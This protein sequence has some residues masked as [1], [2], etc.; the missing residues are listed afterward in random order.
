MF[1]PLR[2]ICGIVVATIIAAAGFRKKSLSRDGAL[3]ACLVGTSHLLLGVRPGILLLAFFYSSSWVTKYEAAQKSNLEAGHKEGG[4]RT[5]VQVLANGGFGTA[6][7]VSHL[8]F[9]GGGEYPIDFVRH[10]WESLLMSMLLGNGDTWASEL[11]I[12][13]KGPVYLVTTFRKVP[14]GTNGGISALG[15]LA[16]V[17]GGL[18]IGTLY[19]LAST[20]LLGGSFGSQW[21][22]ILL[23]ACAG[24]VGSLVDSVCGALFEYSGYNSEDNLVYQKEQRGLKHIAGM[25]AIDGN[26]TNFVSIVVTAL[27]TSFVGQHLYALAASS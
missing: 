19:F 27:L 25:G 23:G 3:C 8:Y 24:F 17:A 21:P 11:G 13:S 14:R 20:F 16:S 5:W 22:S 4:Q 26:A 9:L 12:L 7:C 18:F 6:I 10:Y 2:L 1:S 15:T